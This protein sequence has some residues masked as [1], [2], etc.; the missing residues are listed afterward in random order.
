[1]RVKFIFWILI[2]FF[3]VTITIPC[4]AQPLIITFTGEYYPQNVTEGYIRL[5]I[6][7]EDIR[8][9]WDDGLVQ[10]FIAGD[11]VIRRPTIP[12]VYTV[13]VE[14]DFSDFEVFTA[15]WHM[16]KVEI[17]QW[18]DVELG[19]F[20]GANGA[21]S[22]SADSVIIKDSK[23]PNLSKTT[24]LRNLF[25]PALDGFPDRFVDADFSNWNISTIESISR[26]FER[27]DLGNCSIQE[28][29]VSRI[30]YMNG[31]F[32]NSKHFNCDLSSWDVSNVK[33]MS[34]LFR[35]AEAFDQDLNNWN[36]SNV[37]T[38]VSMFQ[39]ALS[40]NS[41]IDNWN[42]SKV[43]T[44]RSMFQGAASF[45]QSLNDWNVSNVISMSSIFEGATSFNQDLSNWN[46]SNVTNMYSL[47]SGAASFNQDLSNW[48]V[49][50]VT[51]FSSMF[52]NASL[53]NSDLSKWNV[54]NVSWILS[55]FKNARSFNSDLN[56]WDVSGS[57]SFSNMFYGATSFNGD[58][59]SWDVSG[60][61]FF[62]NMFNGAISFNS[63]ISSWTIRWGASLSSMFKSA[64]SFDQDLGSWDMSLKNS[65]DLQDFLTGVSLSID[66]YDSLLIGWGRQN[67]RWGVN[68]DAGNNIPS[69]IGRAARLTISK[70]FGWEIS[71]G[72]GITVTTE[73]PNT[74]PDKFWLSQNY[75][76]PFNPSTK[77]AFN[78]PIATT[79]K[80]DIF[81]SLGSHLQTILNKNILA[82]KYSIYFDA[83]NYSSG[84]YFYKITADNFTET[85][86]MVLIK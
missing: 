80:I 36:V 32:K 31:T 38:M 59:S 4:S 37:I 39:N 83:S 51:N 63:D 13:T 68:F 84:T 50:S 10:D 25:R 57:T 7:K 76:N 74:S 41:K 79:V 58:I 5:G 20:Y 22:W 34:E 26:A 85:K 49:S 46:V 65:G 12:G 28:W 45:N 30:S 16:I 47:F 44:M 66:N 19:Q 11:Y 2:P 82:G 75:P 60:S 73:E 27:T 52:E 15:S 14:G 64:D 1:M 67:L 61:G 33:Q 43:T 6:A 71:D 29:N 54:G 72:D 56:A 17:I 24:A 53:F 3:F 42:V 9:T 40:F 69:D 8:L 77:I 48:N 86:K 62:N 55:M 21:F 23:T 35:G 81:N 78:V 18:G 70:E